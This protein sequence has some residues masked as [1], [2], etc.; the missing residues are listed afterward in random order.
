MLELT[1]DQKDN[2]NKQID[3]VTNIRDLA[4][5]L[6]SAQE[7]ADL[8]LKTSKDELESLI[9]ESVTVKKSVIYVKADE[10]KRQA[11][12]DLLETAR[13]VLDDKNVTKI[14]IDSII[15]KLKQTQL[16][17]NGKEETPVDPSEPGKEPETPVG[18][19][20]PGKEP[21]TPVDPSEPGKEPETPVD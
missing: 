19:S 5:V 11:Y 18:P 20:E 12:D 9:A 13:A 6:K 21:E 8:N 17:L 10:D 14:E 2:F 4:E 16:A 7:Q 1:V 3:E 15:S